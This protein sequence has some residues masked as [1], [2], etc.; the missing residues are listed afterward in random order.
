MEAVATADFRHF[1]VVGIS[2]S[3]TVA[4]D[5]GKTALR[6]RSS[7]GNRRATKP[8]DFLYEKVSN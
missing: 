2:R 3:L 7:V 8:E 1:F 4:R 6:H 5:A